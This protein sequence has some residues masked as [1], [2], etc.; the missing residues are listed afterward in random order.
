MLGAAH[1]NPGFKGGVWVL[2][3][4]AALLSTPV[5]IFSVF[6][7]DINPAFFLAP[8]IGL[9]FIMS[10]GYV[11]GF[12]VAAFLCGILSI[13]A[14]DRLS[15]DG[16]MTKHF[17][18]LTLI[19]FAP[20]FLFLGRAISRGFS[21]RLVIRWLAVFSSIF[22]VVVAGRIL[23][24]DEGVRVYVGPLGLASMNAEFLG[25][26]VFASFGVLSLAHLFCLQAMMICG[27]LVGE[28]SKQ[29][30]VLFGVGLFS[31]AFLIMGSDSRSAQILFA[32]IGFT[33]V[34]YPLLTRE[35]VVRSLV[36]LIIV[37]M[38]AVFSYSRM[39]ESRMAETI[40]AMAEPT[41][42]EGYEGDGPD[43]TA[44]SYA[45]KSDEKESK[46]TLSHS[47]KTYRGADI[48][49]GGANAHSRG[50][51]AV[52]AEEVVQKADA[53]ATGRVELAINGVREVL[54]SPFVGNGFSSYGRYD[55]NGETSEMLKMNTSTHIYYLTL[56]W[57]G[58]LLFAI[59]CLG[60]ML[61]AVRNGWVAR[62]TTD[63]SCARFYTW[64]A[65][66][67]AFGPMACAWDILIVPSAG[68]VAFFLLGVL[69]ASGGSNHHSDTSSGTGL[70]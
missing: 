30:V 45:K 40:A 19:M 1:R 33:I 65:V 66:L 28:K 25:V 2:A 27:A 69:S 50:S 9:A 14:A 29:H 39:T 61:F 3:T 16:E 56:V 12:Y 46:D 58:G 70:A 42:P 7:Y 10:P 23:F 38:G 63:R 44:N 32:W 4:I 15:P 48:M 47:T 43:S 26:P 8:V 17:L 52:T 62:R 54:A 31:A 35:R 53:F 49:S 6:G 64:S 60:M 11:G 34:I 21:V 36:A 55:S 41:S 37:V 24:L 18:S 13:L 68:A 20:S 51:S 22:T 67:M 5:I 59:P 57:K